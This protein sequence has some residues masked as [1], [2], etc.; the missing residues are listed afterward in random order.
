[1]KKTQVEMSR[2]ELLSLPVS[3]D[4]MVAARALGIGRTL[5]YGMAKRGQ[6][7]VRVLRLGNMYRVTRADLLQV[8]GVAEHDTAA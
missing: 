5:A 7:P 2:S 3:F 8:L 6:F 4:L 1:M